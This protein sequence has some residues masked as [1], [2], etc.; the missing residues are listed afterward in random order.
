LAK[1]PKR[2]GGMPKRRASVK[3]NN[4]LPCGF[5]VGCST[6]ATLGPGTTR[7]DCNGRGVRLAFLGKI[8]GN[9]KEWRANMAATQTIKILT[10]FAILSACATVVAAEDDKGPLSALTQCRSVADPAA[11][12][13]CYDK[14]VDALN[15]ATARN[16]VVVM[17]RQQVKETK[18]GLFGFSIGKLP[19]FGRK[20]GKPDAQ[21]EQDDKELATRI[22]KV[23]ALPHGKWRFVV[24]GGAVWET[25]EPVT[26]LK[27]P[28]EGGAVTLEKGSLGSYFAKF[29][30][31][32]KRVAAKRVN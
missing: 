30:E 15:Q 1:S 2:D 17:D 29:G 25:T 10:S 7:D 19:I 20:D 8:N 4:G 16:D 24:D 12:V 13:A 22:T 5:T 32:R 11:R 28:T 26:S 14:A 9:H 21:E 6:I 27:V 18:K 3:Q 31:S 23:R